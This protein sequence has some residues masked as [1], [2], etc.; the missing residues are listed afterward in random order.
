MANR[1]ISGYT[2]RGVLYRL[3]EDVLTLQPRAVVLLIGTND[4]EEMAEPEVASSNV[5]LILDALLQHQPTL[6]VVLC[7]V[8]PSAAS[9]KR[10]SDKII[11]LNQLLFALLKERPQVTF[12]DTWALFAGDKGDARAEE[13]PDLLHPNARAYLNGVAP[14][15]RFLRRC[16]WCPHGR[17]T[18]PRSRA[19]AAC[20]TAVTSV[21]G[22]TWTSLCQ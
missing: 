19:S 20:S 16:S 6:P 2:T 22:A 12:L 3:R 21:A 8:F 13:F 9:K 4:L 10:P 14:C 17:T 11:R 5:A 7:A 18:L 1:G 15:G